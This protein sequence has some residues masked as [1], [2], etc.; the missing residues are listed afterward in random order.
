MN[1]YSNEKPLFVGL[2]GVARREN[3]RVRAALGVDKFCSGVST[4]KH[5]SR[6]VIPQS[7]SND[8]SNKHRKVENST[9]WFTVFCAQ[10]LVARATD[11]PEFPR[12]RLPR[13]GRDGT[14]RTGRG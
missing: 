14:G 1:A 13:D 7:A 8:L 4:K 9:L 6:N 10:S 2:S 5:F 11:A 3:G 12:R